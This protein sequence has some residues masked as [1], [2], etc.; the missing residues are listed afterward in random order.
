MRTLVVLQ[1]IAVACASRPIASPPPPQLP[2]KNLDVTP[3]M[4][5]A[6]RHWLAGD[7]DAAID[8]LVAAGDDPHALGLLA[9][10][11]SVAGRAADARRVAARISPRPDPHLPT[12]VSDSDRIEISPDGAY[13]AVIEGAYDTHPRTRIWNT[14]EGREV[15][16]VDG[17]RAAF[18]V[19]PRGEML[20]AILTGAS[21]LRVVD[22]ATGA[23]RWTHAIE[24]TDGFVV[25]RHDRVI[26]V[27]RSGTNLVE[28]R[29]ST[30]EKLRE[31]HLDATVSY[32]VISADGETLLGKDTL[33]DISGDAT[34][35]AV[36]PGVG[37]HVISPDGG[38]IAR[39]RTN[40]EQIVLFGRDGQQRAALEHA[41]HDAVFLDDGSLLAINGS[42]LTRW[43]VQTATLLAAIELPGDRPALGEGGHVVVRRRSE[44]L[45]LQA[46]AGRADAIATFGRATRAE[47][48]AWSPDG[49]AL[50]FAGSRTTGVWT[51]SSSSA[52]TSTNPNGPHSSIGY[53]AA[54]KLAFDADPS[55]A[56]P[57]VLDATRV[58]VRDQAGHA[59]HFVDAPE[60]LVAVTVGAG[61]VIGAGTS[62]TLYLWRA[63]T[64][65][66]LGTIAGSTMV[67]ALAVRPD[68]RTLAVARE[69]GGIELWDL[70]SRT[71][72]LMLDA[73]E[74]GWVAFTPSG[75]V[76]GDARMLDWGTIPG[77]AI[78]SATEDQLVRKVLAEPRTP[79]AIVPTRAPTLD[80]HAC[81]PADVESLQVWLGPHQGNSLLYCLVDRFTQP[82]S[83]YCFAADLARRTVTPAPTPLDALAP[84]PEPPPPP[85]ATLEPRGTSMY[86]CTPSHVCHSLPVKLDPRSPETD[87]RL[88][89]ISPDGA[90]FAITDDRQEHVETIDVATN[91]RIARFAIRFPDG[92][93]G[94]AFWHH[95]LITTS[96]QCAASCDEGHVYDVHGK[97]LGDFPVEVTE[98]HPQR[99]HD[100]LWVFNDTGGFAIED[101]ITGKVIARHRIPDGDALVIE[102]E[103][104]V[105]VLNTPPGKLLVLDRNANV[106]AEL[107][108]PPRCR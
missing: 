104:I 30:G 95:D 108:P 37:G 86:A 89:A 92:R 106:A 20:V 63:T 103:R 7:L 55:P 9:R 59:V 33:Y 88:F 101:E 68:G 28:W 83:A 21:M 45:M 32:V 67:I 75:R 87:P 40:D 19:G 51:I 46:K 15:I 73:S 66:G 54:G 84:P 96:M 105:A 69:A 43:D 41:G 10:A 36:L 78:A 22:P 47:L 16:A 50:A 94:L 13:V 85:T 11:Y 35:L 23:T 2:P 56:L 4:A 42:R 102:P 91:K 100:H 71:R 90:I 5:A 18:G 93:D 1:I 107:A 48:L 24:E 26:T 74:D 58:F 39:V 65:E 82:V 81:V 44:L 99:F 52:K 80:V 3:R 17:N 76:D 29:L 60:T 79:V 61:L 31:L 64:A 98:A 70:L 12:D 14:L 72:V 25:D 27:P 8:N 57:Y 97:D 34:R 49:D 62:G 53:D 38:T 77:D 6:T